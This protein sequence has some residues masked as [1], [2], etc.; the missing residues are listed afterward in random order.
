MGNVTEMIMI[1]EK[2]ELGE[3]GERGSMK[4]FVRVATT[5]WFINREMKEGTRVI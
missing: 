4:K 1:C 3:G 2:Q 5:V